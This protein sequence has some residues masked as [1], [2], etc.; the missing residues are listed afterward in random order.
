MYVIL[1][2]YS[3]TGNSSSAQASNAYS[4]H[5]K[6]FKDQYENLDRIKSL[7]VGV[8]TQPKQTVKL[9]NICFGNSATIYDT[10]EITSY[11]GN[12]PQ[13]VFSQYN[14]L[15]PKKVFISWIEMK[16]SN[17]YTALI[18]FPNDMT[19]RAKNLPL[20][21]EPGAQEASSSTDEVYIY[22]DLAPDGMITTWLSNS[23]DGI[24]PRSVFEKISVSQATLDTRNPRLLS[25]NGD[26]HTDH[27]K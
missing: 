7:S 2:G 8:S 19:T 10:R 21:N 5:W 4:L 11:G 3:P 27:Q 26:G 24:D 12:I 9:F 23:R 25:C 13:H 18:V 1:G 14:A 20:L 17:W 15:I 16:S 6:F 22:F